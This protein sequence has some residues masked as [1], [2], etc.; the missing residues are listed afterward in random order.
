MVFGPNRVL[1]RN[2]EP[3]TIHPWAYMTWLSGSGISLGYY[4]LQQILDNAY[5][6]LSEAAQSS[7]QVYTP[8]LAK[9]AGF[10]WGRHFLVLDY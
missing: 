4:T 10:A 9:A 3:K 5:G 8:I 2:H 6:V 1:A 7:L